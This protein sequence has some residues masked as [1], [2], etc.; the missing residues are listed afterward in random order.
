M[1][2]W[3]RFEKNLLLE[4]AEVRD[5]GITVKGNLY[6]E[7]NNVYG[8]AH[9]GYLYTISHVAAQLTGELCIGGKWDVR[10]AQCLYLHPLRLYP[11]CVDTTWL[12][13]DPTQPTLR[14][15]VRDGKG[16]LCFEMTVS[17][18]PALPDPDEVVAHTPTIITDRRLPKDPN[19]EPEFPCLSSTFSKWLDIYS[20]SK[21]DTSITYSADLTHRNCDDFGYLHPAVMFT[22]ADC[23]AG[24]CLFYI[25]KRQ[26]ITVSATIH[27][28]GRTCKGPVHAVPTP[29]R[30]GRVLNFYNVDL[31]DGA[32][33]TV[34]TSQFVI[35][36]MNHK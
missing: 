8:I 36:D 1:R 10:S 3:N 5:S 17:L 26:P 34:A 30:K 15:Q 19:V 31:V 22:A 33:Q 32:G 28:F 7:F 4:V 35:Q 12:H 13:K 25:D 9:G 14:A 27:Y 11:A 21:T 29:I 23:A 20:T 18:K 16:N 6:E 24:G 2:N